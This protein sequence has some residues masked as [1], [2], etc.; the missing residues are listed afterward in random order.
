MKNYSYNPKSKKT[1]FAM[2]HGSAL[3]ISA[4]DAREVALSIRGESVARAEVILG[5]VIAKTKPIKFTRHNT[6]V[7]HKPGIGSG[8][9]PVN[10]AKDFLLLLKNAKSNASAKGLDESRLYVVTACA[11]RSIYKR[12][13]GARV[14]SK[15]PSNHSRRANIEIVLEEKLK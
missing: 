1:R 14:F 3:H 10:A 9:F 8:R 6:E 15:G 11:N 12:P 7:G 2:A 13:G 5:G 4:K